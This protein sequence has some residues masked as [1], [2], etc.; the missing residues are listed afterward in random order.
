MTVRRFISGVLWKIEIENNEGRCM[1]YE[2]NFPW[3]TYGVCL[4]SQRMG[5]RNEERKGGRY[6]RRGKRRTEDIVMSKINF[7]T[8]RKCF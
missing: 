1:G 2:F 6:G 4:Y 7:S 5:Y 3:Y 8:G